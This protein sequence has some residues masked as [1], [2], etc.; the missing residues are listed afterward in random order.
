[1]AELCFYHPLKA[2]IGLANTRHV[3]S[4]GAELAPATREL[5]QGMGLDLTQLDVTDCGVAMRN[6]LAG[7]EE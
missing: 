7:I 4:F 3:Y 6:T 5:W 2:R 1:M